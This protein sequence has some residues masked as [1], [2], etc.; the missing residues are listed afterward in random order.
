MK[1]LFV[2]MGLL[3]AAATVTV[4][5]ADTVE[6]GLRIMRASDQATKSDTEVTRYRMELLGADG[7]LVQAREL[8]F[9]FK[10]LAGKEATLVRFLA[11]A[12]IEDTGLLIE[13]AGR[14]AND[15]WLYLP[16][17]RRLR[18]IAGA[19]KTNW[20]MGTEFTHEDFEDYQL[21]LYRFERLKDAACGSGTCDVVAASPIDAAERKA[22]G[23]ARKVY[24]IDRASRYPVRIE[25]YGRDGKLAKTLTATGM[26]R[27]GDYW[28]PQQLEM[29]NLANGRRTRLRSLS[30]ALDESLDDFLVSSR[31]L[32]AD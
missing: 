15:V 11:P 20:F 9:H 4:A 23:Y 18:R 22:S 5:Q 26:T 21:H 7:K 32:R 28:R 19:E 3:A 2:A 14:S 16:A 25:Y 24:F 12:A 10:K 8:L 29:H 31:Y 13:D 17:T 1:S 27:H 6:D 30:R